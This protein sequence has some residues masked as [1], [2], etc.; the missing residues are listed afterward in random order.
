[1]KRV[2]FIFIGISLL[3]TG[4]FGSSTD[5]KAT[6]KTLEGFHSYATEEIKLQIPDDWEVLTP[7]N[8]LVAFRSNIRNPMYTVNVVI[9]KNELAAEIGTLDY[10]KILYEK[11]KGELTG[12]HEILAEEI[13][14]HVKGSETDTLFTV[15]EGRESPDAD[16]KHFMQ[17]SAVSGKKA[18]IA[19][20]SMLA[21]D[22][23]GVSK[24]IETMVRS[25]EVK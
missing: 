2:S 24:M 17:V 1:M 10:A 13:K 7:E 6:E 15:F 9:I 19:T 8:T 23:E 25:F 5:T 12:F 3:L 18:Y 22:G 4:C 14:T 20:G 21:A 16:L 11:V